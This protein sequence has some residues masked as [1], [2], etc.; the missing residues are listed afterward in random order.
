MPRRISVLFLGLIVPLWLLVA[1]A[2]TIK[3]V[4]APYTSPASG[5]AMYRT[6]CAACH[7][8]E[9]KG[10][11]PAATALKMA[12]ANLTTLA[13]ANG[14]QFPSDRVYNSIKGD[15]A[16]AAHGSPEMPV[17]GTTFRSVS[18]GHPVEVQQRLVNLTSYVKTLQEN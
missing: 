18:H 11:G 8:L 15:P 13:K 6:H 14:G 9:G 2:Q 12:P 5:K 1:S 3:N 4:P 17:W 7:G 10:D 16:V